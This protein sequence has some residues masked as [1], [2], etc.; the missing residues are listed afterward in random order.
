MTRK[1]LVSQGREDCWAPLVADADAVYDEEVIIDL[2]MV[3][4]LVAKPHSPDNV[5]PVRELAGLVLDQVAIG[6]CTNSSYADLLKAAKILDGKQIHP[7]V[8]L[9]IAPGSRQVLS[10]LAQNG[11]LASLINAGARILESACGYCIGMGQAPRSGG[12]SLRTSNRNFEGRS[13][14]PDAQI[15]LASPEVAAASALT[16][17]LT[18]PRTLGGTLVVDTEFKVDA[19]DNLFIFP[20]AD[21][22]VV[23]VVRG[24]NI[25]PFPRAKSL[26]ETLTGEVLLKADNNITTDHIMPSHAHLLPYRSNIPYLAGYC[27]SGIDPTFPER[28]KAKQGGFIVAGS[29]YGQGSSREHAA[30][31]PLYLGVKGVVAK[32]FARIHRANLINFGIVPMTFVDEVDYDDVV[33]GDVLTI[34]KILEQAKAGSVI[35]AKCGV[36]GKTIRLHLELTAREIEMLLAGGLLNHTKQQGG[37]Q[38]A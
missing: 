27:L 2:S 26:P 25:K 34:E 32:S 9:I 24:P 7:N 8:S 5:A 10:L 23:E 16:G 15:Y 3:E 30:L 28:A 12:I 6:S 38:D 36:Q 14:T 4:P 21:G 19:N 13:G 20:P 18:D 11:A 31:A 17:V 35:L 29:N 22:A 33:Q 1:F 37:I